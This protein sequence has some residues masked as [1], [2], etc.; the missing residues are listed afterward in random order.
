MKRS[1][2][3]N[4]SADEVCLSSAYKGLQLKLMKRLF[5]LG[6]SD[7]CDSTAHDLTLESSFSRLDCQTCGMHVNLF[8]SRHHTERKTR[9]TGL[10]ACFW[11]NHGRGLFRDDSFQVLDMKIFIFKILFMLPY[12]FNLETYFFINVVRRFL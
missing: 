12:H 10:L 6:P 4:L 9:M 11:S 3:F 5:K 2:E 1:R 7:R 8:C